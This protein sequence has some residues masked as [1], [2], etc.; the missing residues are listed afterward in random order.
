MERI[1]FLKIDPLSP[2]NFLLSRNQIVSQT[3]THDEPETAL[4]KILAQHGVSHEFFVP[5]I[6][7]QV[8]PIWGSKM[9][10]LVT[11]GDIW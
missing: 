10:H 3:T 6:F 9:G 5:H 4:A 2:A 8:K 11:F 1:K 7:Q